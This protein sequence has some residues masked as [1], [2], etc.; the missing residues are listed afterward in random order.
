[1]TAI[2]Q[3]LIKAQEILSVYKELNTDTKEVL[4]S[5]DPI[6]RIRTFKKVAIDPRSKEFVKL[7][8]KPEK[9]EK[10]VKSIKIKSFVAKT[11]KV[12]PIK[13]KKQKPIKVKTERKKPPFQPNS[14]N[15]R[16]YKLH[17]EG[18]SN[19]EIAEQLNVATAI[20][21]KRI[22]E[23]K[24]QLGFKVPKKEYVKFED[25][26]KLFYEGKNYDEMSSIL[27]IKE[28]SIYPYIKIIR[29]NLRPEHVENEYQEILNAFERIKIE[30]NLD[31]CRQSWLT[32]LE[33]KYKYLMKPSI[34]NQC[35]KELI[36]SGRFKVDENDSQKYLGL[37]LRS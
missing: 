8:G 19:I 34:V 11:L 13:I 24:S 21:N 25:V 1:M 10:P 3:D 31:Y 22:K 7:Y 36:E 15:T 35:I 2:N 29:A 37:K 28:G 4:S 30:K 32:S 27:G 18:F 20:V 12:K 17:L 9:K 6:L 14:L 16:C 33:N 26:E 23:R 5:Y